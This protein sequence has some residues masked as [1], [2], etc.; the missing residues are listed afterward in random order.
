M[1]VITVSREMGSGSDEIV[2]K[3]CNLLSYT[4]VNKFLLADTAKKMKISEVDFFDLNEEEYIFRSFI[5]KLLGRNEI[6]Q[7]EVISEDLFAGDPEQFRVKFWDVEDTV[8]VLRSL[9]KE[10][11]KKGNMVIVG[12]GGQAIL[13]DEKDTLH[14]RIIAP[15]DKRVDRIMKSQDITKDDAKKYIRERD[16]AAAQ[17]LKRFYKIDWNDPSLYDLWINTGKL[18]SEQSA[19]AIVAA[20]KGPT[21]Q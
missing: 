1:T 6:V 12:R 21:I 8:T 19:A 3:V 9:I 13:K 16:R 18:N 17:Y 7:A 5:E 14:V 4:Y 11:S 10:L 20:V 2:E 15:F